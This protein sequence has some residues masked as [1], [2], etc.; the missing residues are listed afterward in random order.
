MNTFSSTLRETFFFLVRTATRCPFLARV[1]EPIFIMI[2]SNHHHYH[3]HQIWILKLCV[4][5][6][7]FS[8]PGAGNGRPETK[9]ILEWIQHLKAF[10]EM[11]VCLVWP[12][13]PSAHTHTH[14]HP[15]THLPNKTIFHFS[16]FRSL[17]SID[18]DHQVK[19]ANHFQCFY[20]NQEEEE[21]NTKNFLRSPVFS[22][23]HLFP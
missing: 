18:W 5:D 17:V 2:F 9:C 10:L 6:I 21:E 19:Y 23:Q 3:H 7:L 11:P 1:R 14:T 22:I 4:L 8:A 16:S 13:T 15:P 20:W 12:M